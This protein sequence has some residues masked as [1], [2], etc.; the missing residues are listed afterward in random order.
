[1]RMINL[2]LRPTLFL[3]G[4]LVLSSAVLSV[5]L[6]VSAL[7][8]RPI[9]IVPGAENRQV[10]VPEQIPDAAVKKFGL[11]YLSYFDAYTPTTIEERSNYVLRLVAP[12]Q[13]EAVVKSLSERATFVVRARESCTLV[14]PLPEA[15]G[16]AS[17][18]NGLIRFSTVAERRILIAGSLKSVEQVEYVL[19]LRPALPSE[20]DP[21]GLVVVRQSIRSRGQAQ[22]DDD[23]R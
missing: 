9:V 20:V 4:V 1:M 19:D 11:L 7:R 14:L 8:P 12:E 13:L 2:Q 5:A 10:V 6:A 15:C 18:A 22:V 16:V 3:V 23:R 17:V 21:Y